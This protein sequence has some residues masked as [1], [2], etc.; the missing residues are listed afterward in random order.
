MFCINLSLKKLWSSHRAS[1][2]ISLEFGA[3][4]E[5]AHPL[6]WKV[7]KL[8]VNLTVYITTPP[9]HQKKKPK[10]LELNKAMHTT[11][12]KQPGSWN[13]TTVCLEPK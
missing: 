3:W 10:H 11:F 6:N 2:K 9:P 7:V 12:G 1:V 13:V 5:K 4:S 8:L